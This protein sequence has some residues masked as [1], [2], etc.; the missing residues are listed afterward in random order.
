V[1]ED[2]L[3]IPTFT[4]TATALATLVFSAELWQ[5][6]IISNQAMVLGFALT[7][8][9]GIPTG[10]AMGRFQ[11]LDRIAAP[12]ISILLAAP[13]AMFIPLLIMSTGIGLTSRVILVFLFSVITVVVNCSAGVRSVDRSLIEMSYSFGA[14]ERVIWWR[15]LL[16]GALPAV[17][18][19][20]RIGLGRAVG[21]MIIV[22][23]L[24]VAVGLGGLMLKYQGG[25]RPGPLYATVI[26]VVL[27]ALLVIAIA[28]WFER[29]VAPW[30][31][32]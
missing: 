10:L 2:S 27:E 11:L 32:R 13:M 28:H 1:S 16:P 12:Y 31:A 6:V 22:E 18:A 9:V 26:V 4:A 5:A 29:K 3:L 15:V 20:V 8:A 21:G 19:G 30:A 14:S 17:M 25:F 24:M 7:L 23:L